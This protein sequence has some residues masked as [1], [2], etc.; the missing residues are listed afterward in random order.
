[1]FTLVRFDDNT[2]GIYLS[3][4]ISTKEN[5]QCIVNHYGTKYN[6]KIISNG[7]E[8]YFFL[9]LFTILFFRNERMF[10]ENEG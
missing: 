1:M 4:K 8:C 9:I 6:A 2:T 5:G 10:I 3:K 7:K